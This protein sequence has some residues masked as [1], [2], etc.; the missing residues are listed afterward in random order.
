LPLVGH[1]IYNSSQSGVT[2][3]VVPR[4]SADSGGV[5]ENRMTMQG[6]L[7]LSGLAG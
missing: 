4:L 7:R 3:V 6:L 1:P 2:D 5:M